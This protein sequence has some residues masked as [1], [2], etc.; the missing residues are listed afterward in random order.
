M[1][2]SASITVNNLEITKNLNFASVLGA[3]RRMD[4]IVDEVK[5]NGRDLR[6]DAKI[7][8][9]TRSDLGHYRFFGN[10]LVLRGDRRQGHLNN[11]ESCVP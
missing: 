5:R 11:R 7:T 3:L 4:T 8:I 10:S 2:W 1:A 9:H 6:V